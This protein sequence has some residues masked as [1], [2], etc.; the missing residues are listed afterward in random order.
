MAAAPPRRHGEPRRC[1]YASAIAKHRR[2][3]KIWLRAAGGVMVCMRRCSAAGQ[4]CRRHSRRDRRYRGHSSA[5]VDIISTHGRRRRRRPP[6]RQMR[7]AD[8]KPPSSRRV[9]D[10]SRPMACAASHRASPR[11]ARAGRFRPRASSRSG[12]LIARAILEL[13]PGLPSRA[14]TARRAAGRRR[15]RYGAADEVPGSPPASAARRPMAEAGGRGRSC[16]MN[17]TINYRR[18]QQASIRMLVAAGGRG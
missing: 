3:P 1:H 2:T 8:I 10:Q 17:S 15:R 9:A 7:L 12:R 5:D 11:R 13:P 18:E 4:R 6:L 16:G 14:P